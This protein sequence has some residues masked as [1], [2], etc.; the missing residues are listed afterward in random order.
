MIGWLA[1]TVAIRRLTD[2]TELL[3]AR[4]VLV[5]AA[6]MVVGVTIHR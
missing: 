1:R 4:L 2:P 6:A 3:R 5:A